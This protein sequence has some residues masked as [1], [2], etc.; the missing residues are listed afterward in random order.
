MLSDD[1]DEPPRKQPR[2]DASAG[3]SKRPGEQAARA[4][5]ASKR[6]VPAMSEAEQFA[7]QQRLFEEARRRA[8]LRAV[9]QPLAAYHG[10]W[11]W[12][13]QTLAAPHGRGGPGSIAGASPP[14]AASSSATA[15]DM[16]KC[17]KCTLENKPS[18]Q[19]CAACDRVR[20]GVRFSQ[21][22]QASMHRVM[23]V[24][25]QLREKLL[26]E[27]PCASMFALA[28]DR[29]ALELGVTSAVSSSSSEA[30]ELERAIQESIEACLP[31]PPI[32]AC[33]PTPPIQESIEVPR[34]RSTLSSHSA[35]CL[36]TP[37]KDAT[38]DVDSSDWER[39]LL[40]TPPHGR[41]ATSASKP[42]A[43]PSPP[44]PISAEGPEWSSARLK[45]DRDS[46][47]SAAEGGMSRHAKRAERAAAERAAAAAE[48]SGSIR[49]AKR[50]YNTT[51]VS[52]PSEFRSGLLPAAPAPMGELE[53]MI[54]GKRQ[55]L[56]EQLAAAQREA[57]QLRAALAEEA[58]KRGALEAQVR[59]AREASFSSR[60]P[61]E[62][63]PFQSDQPDQPDWVTQ[64]EATAQA[65][66]EQVARRRLP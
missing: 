60:T 64:A 54:A 18:V 7:Q 9:P 34:P 5:G 12:Q 11:A 41:P 62:D 27:K 23:S 8:A 6:P 50:A 43:S 61:S 26:R 57:A 22:D 24:N 56:H 37:P 52:V 53:S 36:P 4:S 49:G 33:L 48:G 51:G 44:K 35:A 38:V 25:P 59:M 13:H 16:W 31:T 39:D 21:L 29:L 40:P 3:A 46:G 20:P 63:Q 45:A 17:S 2:T 42:S 66:A 14:A 1:E 10:G 30:A 19:V 55:S 32:E 28:Q 47:R 58:A 15:V 65:A